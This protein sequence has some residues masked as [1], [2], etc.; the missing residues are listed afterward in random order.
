MRG[1]DQHLFL[2]TWRSVRG[3][4]VIRLEGRAVVQLTDVGM[5]A[6]HHGGSC[7]EE[8]AATRTG[9]RAALASGPADTVN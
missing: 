3:M 6:K 8:A 7:I 5:R 1:L 9:L 4:Q 2:K